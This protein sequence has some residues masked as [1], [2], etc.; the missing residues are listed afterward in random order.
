V[1]YSVQ[2]AASLEVLPEHL[3][4]EV[5][6]TMQQIA[7]V[8]SSVP[9]ASPF[10]SSMRDSVLQ[11]DIGGWR[12]GYKVDRIRREIRVAELTQIR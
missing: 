8:V 2:F 5:G 12:V 4:Q 7:E 10:W 11:I 6:R 3:R 1:T 9:E